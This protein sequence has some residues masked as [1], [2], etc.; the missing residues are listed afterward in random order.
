[1]VKVVRVMKDDHFVCSCLQARDYQFLP[2]SKIKEIGGML[3]LQCTSFNHG[4]RTQGPNTMLLLL[5]ISLG[6]VK[7]KRAEN[8]NVLHYRPHTLSLK[9]VCHIVHA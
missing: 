6:D 5:S 2:P 9:G 1:M 4:R 3:L 8:H 7:V